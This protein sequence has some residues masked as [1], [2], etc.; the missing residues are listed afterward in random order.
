[1]TDNPPRKG[2][3]ISQALKPAKAVLPGIGEVAVRIRTVSFLKWF[4]DGERARRWQDGAEFLRIL[5]RERV[6]LPDNLEE[7]D[8]PGLNAAIVDALDTDQLEA[9]AEQ[10]L[11]AAGPVFRSLGARRKRDAEQGQIPELAGTGDEGK[12]SERLLAGARRYQLDFEAGQKDAARRLTET[13]GVGS[14]IRE[15]DRHNKLTQLSR[16]L[17]SINLGTIGQTRFEHLARGDRFGRAFREHDTLSKLFAANSQ[18]GT[19]GNL[20]KYLGL[21]RMDSDRWTEVSRMLGLGI[22]SSVLAAAQGLTASSVLTPFEHEA[23][24]MYRPGY[25]SIASL[26]L[27]G[28]IGRGAAS[29]LLLEYDADRSEAPFF[30]SVL[31]TIEALDDDETTPAERIALLETVVRLIRGAGSWATSPVDRNAII[32]LIGVLVGILALYPELI[33]FRGKPEPNK[34][35]VAATAEIKALREDLAASRDAEPR[36]HI[37]YVHGRA[38]LRVAP[39]RHGLVIRIVYSDQWVEVRE[40]RGDW[41]RVAVYDYSSDAPVEGWIHRRNLRLVPE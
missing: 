23:A 18:I 37:R 13:L 25:Q 1:M 26:A 29:D 41:A 11:L 38:N 24:A 9:V 22:P 40:G 14:V 39:E 2:F 16:G 3:D 6:A 5:L 19:I 31:D 35:I 20:S 7:A 28:E 4:G 33:P 15:L 32:G 8:G 12:P 34:E 17:D 10:L 30:N 27:D 36:Q 21:N